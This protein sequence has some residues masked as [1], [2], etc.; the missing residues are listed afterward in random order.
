MDPPG[1]SRG[2]SVP[3]RLQLLEAACTPWLLTLTSVSVLT[4]LS[5]TLLLIRTLV[6]TLSSSK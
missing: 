4:S 2:E 5:L 6:I 1:G 3:G